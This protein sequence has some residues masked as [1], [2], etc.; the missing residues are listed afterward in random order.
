MPKVRYNWD[1]ISS[2]DITDAI[3][4]YIH[5]EKYREI[6]TRRLLFGDKIDDIANRVD[7][8][9]RQIQNI[10]YKCEDVIFKHIIIKG[11]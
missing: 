11:P 5:R 2:N 6:I 10:I 8:S 4:Q 1:D 3:N 7:M 9:P